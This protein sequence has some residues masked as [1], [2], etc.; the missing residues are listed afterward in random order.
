MKRPKLPKINWRYAFGELTIVVVGILIAVALNAWWQGRQI[1]I[2][3]EVVLREIHDALQQDLGI[4][5]TQLSTFHEKA[6]RIEL[7]SDHLARGGP[8]DDTLDVYFGAV[9]GLD[10]ITV[11]TSPYE[12]LKSR[13][14][15]L[16]SDASLRSEVTSLYD[17]GYDNLDELH[18]TQRSAVLDLM[19]PYFL[20]HFEK[21]DFGKSATP[22]SYDYVRN[23]PYFRNLMAYRRQI[24]VGAEI[25]F[26]EQTIEAVRDLSA[27]IEAELNP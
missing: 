14:T 3:E 18:Q 10:I 15:G 17:L 16:I 25:P 7:L 23:D 8:Y 13:G 4:L 12:S 2:E 27:A 24:I 1:A 5:T 22:V 11:N 9:Y 26:Y 19:R 20:S 6:R 21:L